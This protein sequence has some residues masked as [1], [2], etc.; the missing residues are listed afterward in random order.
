MGFAAVARVTDEKWIACAVRDEIAFGLK[1]GGE[2]DLQTTICHEIRQSGKGVIIDHVAEDPEFCGHHTPRT[3]GFQSYISLPILLKN[4]DFFGTLCAIDP[5]PAKLNNPAIIGMFKLFAELIAFHLQ[6]AEE[7]RTSQSSLSD[8]RQVAE[9][10]EQF[11]AVLGHDLLNPLSAVMNSA[12]LLQRTSAEED[13]QQLAAVI[14]HSATRMS[15]LIENTLDFAQGR[16]GGGIKLARK[17]CDSLTVLFHQLIAEQQAVSPDRDILIGFDLTEAVTCDS[18]RIGQLF[19]NLLGN[20]LK[21]GSP[22]KPVR[23]KASSGQGMF[24]LSVANC[25][26][27]ISSRIREHIF[28]P[29]VRGEVKPGQQGL[30]LGLYIAAEIARAHGGCLQVSSTEEETIFTLTMPVAE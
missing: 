20:A 8:E 7:L 1:P 2:L 21:Y 13:T 27:P 12:L 10:R 3:Y 6:S 19:S 4:G 23:I 14:Q 17:P 9:L 15:F 24:Y 28:Q 25:G 18:V 29:F 5:R 22:D 30:G 11:I 16:L 26:M